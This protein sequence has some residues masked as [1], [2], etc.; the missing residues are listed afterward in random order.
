MK[1]ETGRERD[2]EREGVEHREREWW[3]S[4]GERGVRE[5]VRDICPVPFL[6]PLKART[7]A[8]SAPSVAATQQLSYR[9]GKRSRQRPWRRVLATGLVQGLILREK[10]HSPLR[11]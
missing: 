8:L 10:Q 1:R 9:A 4:G 11:P 5:E 2:R 3:E 6:S 7:L